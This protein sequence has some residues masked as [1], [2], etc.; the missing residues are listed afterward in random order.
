MTDFEN[1]LKTQITYKLKIN[2]KGF[3]GFG[4][5]FNLL[6]G[7]LAADA[8]RE[9]EFVELW[10]PLV[11]LTKNMIVGELFKVQLGI[12]GHFQLK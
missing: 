2:K 8:C 10:L 1:L 6:S 5:V 11:A 9:K 12:L 7:A 4:V 3:W